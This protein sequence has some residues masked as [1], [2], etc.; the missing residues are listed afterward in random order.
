MW[1]VE[2]RLYKFYDV[3]LPYAVSVKQVVVFAAAAAPW[4]LLMSGLKIPPQ[5]PYGF[6]L[7]VAPPVA[8][9]FAATRPVA[10][11]KK[12]FEY[13][14]SQIRFWFGGRTYAALKKTVAIR[15]TPL[16]VDVWTRHP[17]MEGQTS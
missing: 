11:G 6:I 13:L 12:L 17:P 4:L 9:T 14:G 16:T 5:N 3:A 10:E 1:S 15:E 8:I 2:K 7:W